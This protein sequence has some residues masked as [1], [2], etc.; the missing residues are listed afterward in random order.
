MFAVNILGLRQILPMLPGRMPFL[1]YALPLQNNAMDILTT[2][3]LHL[4]EITINDYLDLCEILQDPEVMYAWEHTFTHSQVIT[5]LETQ[6]ERYS[7]HGIGLWAVISKETGAFLGQAGLTMQDCDGKQVLEIGYLF[8]KRYWHQG[9]A[10]EAAIECRQYAFQKLHAPEVY[11]IIRDTNLPSQKVAQRNGMVPVG[12]FVKHYNGI[13]MPHIIY[14]M[15][16][17]YQ[18]SN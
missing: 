7:A 5:H 2:S 15:K 3:R 1:K 18:T 8:K 12:R 6:L 11:S 4:R 9:Y 16:N 10:T 17:P 13:D 14:C